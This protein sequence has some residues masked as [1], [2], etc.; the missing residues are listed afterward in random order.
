[1]NKIIGLFGSAA[2]RAVSL[3]QDLGLPGANATNGL[4]VDPTALI[5]DG[6][7]FT[8]DAGAHIDG[9]TVFTVNLNAFV[10]DNQNVFQLV[11]KAVIDT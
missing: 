11:K 7:V 10:D 1:M 8:I 3:R 5:K 9:D 6:S 2:V 4:K